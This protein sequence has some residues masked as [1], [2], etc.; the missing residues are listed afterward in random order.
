MFSKKNVLG[1]PVGFFGSTPGIVD[2]FI[3]VFL[4]LA[5]FIF[6]DQWYDMNATAQQSSDLLDLIFKGKPLSFYTFVLDKANAGGY[7]PSAYDSS[8][9]PSAAYNIVLYLILAIWE[10]P[11]YVINHISPT[12]YYV[13]ILELWARFLSI[14]LTVICCFQMIKLSE[15]LMIDK[16]KAKWAGYYFISSPLIVY[17]III[18]NQLDIVPVLLIILAL[19]QYFKKKYASFCLFMAVACCFKL[20]PIF[21]V[22]PLLCLA[23]KRITK[24]LQ[25]IFLSISLYAVTTIIPIL[26]DPGYALI[27]NGVMKSDAFSDYIFKVVIPGGDSNASVFLLIFFLLCVVAYI[28]KPKV[29]DFPIFAVMLGFASLAN[30]FLFVKWHPQWMVLLL[31]FITLLVFSLIDFELGIILDI[32]LTLGFLVTS[33]IIHLTAMIFTSSIFYALTCKNYAPLDNYNPIYFFFIEH[34]YT[35]LIPSTLLF[36]GIAGLFLA[37]FLNNR[38]SSSDIS[39]PFDNKYKVARGWFYTRSALIL[40]YILPPLISYL[41]HPIR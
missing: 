7:L 22:I 5:A 40:V 14:L 11:I 27:Q 24:L 21:I 19:K 15:I 37:A 38:S 34:G 17:C 23:E 39:S 1:K 20:M 6:Y 13:D 26:A 25:Y 36:A 4:C 33:I 28:V 16:T 29:K 32:A 18:R 3:V 2:A 30:F 41:S 10:L 31:P 12:K 8:E 35:T 9:S